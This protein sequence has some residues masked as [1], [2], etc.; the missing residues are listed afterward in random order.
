VMLAPEAQQ[1]LVNSRI[2]TATFTTKKEDIK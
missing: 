1:A 2:I